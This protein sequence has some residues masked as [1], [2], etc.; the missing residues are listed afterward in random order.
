VRAVVRSTEKTESYARLS[1]ETG[2]EDGKGTIAPVW[3]TRDVSFEGT[4]E[5]SSFNLASLV[6]LPGDLLDE[7][8]LRRACSGVDCIVWCAASKPALS[9]SAGIGFFRNIGNLGKPDQGGGSSIE[10]EGVSL[11]AKC[12]KEDLRRRGVGF[13]KQAE[14]RRQPISFVLLTKAVKASSNQRRGE[15]LL[16]DDACLPSFVVVRSAPFDDFF[17]AASLDDA[18]QVDGESNTSDVSARVFRTEISSVD[19]TETGSSLK[20]PGSRDR[21]ISRAEVAAFLAQSL[22]DRSLK[23]Q[24]VVI[25]TR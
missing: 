5:M 24:Q 18:D 25:S 15:A 19:S 12:L 9:L 21:R 8:F 16:V 20:L 11:A 14:E 22:T 10:A 1:Y 3:V 4:D 6:V 2:A 13:E 23:N 17:G 7:S